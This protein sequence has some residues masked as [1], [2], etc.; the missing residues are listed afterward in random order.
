MLTKVGFIGLKLDGEDKEKDTIWM[1]WAITIQK[2][3]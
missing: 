2:M 1:V 3:F